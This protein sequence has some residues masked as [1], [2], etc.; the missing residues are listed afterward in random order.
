MKW[1][2]RLHGWQPCFI[3]CRFRFQISARWLAVLLRS[4]CSS[5]VLAAISGTEPETADGRFSHIPVRSTF[6]KL[7]SSDQTQRRMK[8]RRRVLQDTPLRQ[9]PCALRCTWAV[10]VQAG[11]QWL[12]LE[13]VANTGRDK[14]EQIRPAD[15]TETH[16]NT[17]PS[18]WPTLTKPLPSLSVLW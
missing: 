5:S 3:F 16:R 7:L 4:P 6:T 2:F 12:P 15:P 17:H 10:P 14:F 13:A 18:P 9:K 8:K 1:L 11:K